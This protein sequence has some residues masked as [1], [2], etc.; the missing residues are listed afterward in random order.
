MSKKD[1]AFELFNRDKR[2]SDEE[3]KKLGLKPKTTYNYYQQWEKSKMLARSPSRQGELNET[4]ELF[5]SPSNSD[6]Y[7]ANYP[8]PNVATCPITPIMRTAINAAVEQWGWPTNMPIEDYIDTLV[9]RYFKDKGIILCD[10]GYMVEQ[11]KRSI[12]NES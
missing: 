10:H 1:K 2:P 7:R 9:Y 3:I 5:T 11:G 8:H 12:K 6:T 4:S